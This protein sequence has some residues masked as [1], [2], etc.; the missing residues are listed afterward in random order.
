MDSENLTFLVSPGCKVTFCLSRG[1]PS[2]LGISTLGELLAQV[3]RT[4]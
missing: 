3:V 1:K 2:S 4:G